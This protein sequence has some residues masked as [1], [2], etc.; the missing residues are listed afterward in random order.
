MKTVK[1]LNPL[2]KSVEQYSKYENGIGHRLLDF[3]WDTVFPPRCTFCDLGL[4]NGC[5]IQICDECRSSIE[6]PEGVSCGRCGAATELP[7][8]N[9]HVLQLNGHSANGCESS[10]DGRGGSA[11]GR[12]CRVCREANYHFDSA[13]AVGNYLGPLR[14]IVLRMKRPDQESVAIQMGRILGDIVYDSDFFGEIDIVTPVPIHWTKHLIRGTNVAQLL[15]EG[16]CQQI[17]VP[18]TDSM[19]RYTRRTAKQGTLTRN[20]RFSNVKDSMELASGYQIQDLQVLLVDDVMTSGATASE[21]AKA[22]LRAGAARVYV[23]VVARGVGV[24]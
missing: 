8:A 19:L 6:N 5:E 21:A 4:P 2:V 15:T 16:V 13:V 18:D 20:Q 23:A 22:L 24:S 7:T 11:E 12:S 9:G 1:T 10:F 3:L 14:D 17:G